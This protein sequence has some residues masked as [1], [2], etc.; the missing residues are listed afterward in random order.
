MKRE[1]VLIKKASVVSWAWAGHSV[2]GNS[3]F[4]FKIIDDATGITYTGKTRQ[5]SG[6]TGPIGRSPVLLTDVRL[7]GA[8][9]TDANP[10]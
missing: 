2:V 1:I 8:S 10:A 6:F 7:C 9:M 3:F 4:K 5:N